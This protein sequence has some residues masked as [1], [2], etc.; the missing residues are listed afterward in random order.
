MKDTLSV[1]KGD[2]QKGLFFLFSAKWCECDEINLAWGETQRYVQG[3][4]VPQA[5]KHSKTCCSCICLCPGIQ[6]SSPPSPVGQLIRVSRRLFSKK[7]FITFWNSALTGELLSMCRCL[8]PRVH[9]FFFSVFHFFYCFCHHVDKEGLIKSS[10]V[11][12][13]TN[14]EEAPSGLCC[15]A[16][17]CVWRRAPQMRHVRIGSS[18]RGAEAVTDWPLF[19]RCFECGHFRT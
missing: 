6:V 13:T 7:H 15:C 16:I 5:G 2:Q 9:H 10:S 14:W 8:L 11:P 1:N 19:R 17:A 3:E 12:L 18:E 4:N